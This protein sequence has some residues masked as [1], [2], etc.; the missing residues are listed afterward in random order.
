MKNEYVP[1]SVGGYNPAGGLQNRRQPQRQALTCEKCGNSLLEERRVARFDGE[2]RVL[3]GS[4]LPTLTGDPPY[5]VY[6]CLVC[7][8]PVMPPLHFM[9]V[10]PGREE[11]HQILQYYMTEKQEEPENAG[12]EE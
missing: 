1:I 7:K 9:G 6:I 10:D 8:Q 2:Q 12:E 4:P 5:L 11:Y 3:L